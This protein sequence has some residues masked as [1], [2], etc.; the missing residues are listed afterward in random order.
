MC[1]G[2]SRKEVEGEMQ[3]GRGRRAGLEGRAGRADAGSRPRLT[4]R[5]QAQAVADGVVEEECRSGQRD[6]RFAIGGR[7]SNRVSA[8]IG[9]SDDESLVVARLFSYRSY[10]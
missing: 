5:M 8:A 7:A 3:T 6:V 4:T 1:A 9:R 10:V 2:G